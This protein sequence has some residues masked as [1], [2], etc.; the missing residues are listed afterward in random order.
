MKVHNKKSLKDIRRLLRSELTPAEKI[1]WEELRGRK[2][3]NLKFQRQHSIGNY[4]VDFYCAKLRLIIELEGAVHFKKEQKQKDNFRD[5][6]LVEMD[7]TVLRITNNEI[8]DN[9]SAILEK[10]KNIPFPSPMSRRGMKG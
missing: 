8:E 5:K 2:L 7:Y 3:N 1:L 10:I 4:I 6:N 9:L